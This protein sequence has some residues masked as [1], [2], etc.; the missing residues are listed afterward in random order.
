[1]T[2]RISMADAKFSFQCPGRMY[3]PAW[4]APE[5]TPT[6]PQFSI[7]SVIYFY[8]HHISFSVWFDAN[9]VHCF[10]LNHAV[11]CPHSELKQTLQP[12]YSYS[13]Q[14]CR[15]NPRTSIDDR[16][17]C[18]ALRCCCG[19]WS[20]ERCPLLTSRTWRSA[21]RWVRMEIFIYFGLILKLY[22]VSSPLLLR[23]PWKVCVPR[24]LLG[25]HL[26]S[27]SWCGSAWTKTQPRDRSLTWSFPSWRRCKT[28][29]CF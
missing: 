9:S 28:N 11:S 29:K 12:I 19:S 15:R 4:M 14:P 24:S 16:Q 22:L 27:V 13:F 6:P 21:W 5:G 20:P 17:I 1:M 2:A 7:P 23:W 18:G 8:R 3:S 10:A 25:F 26:I